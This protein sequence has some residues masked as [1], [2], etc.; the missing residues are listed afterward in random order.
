[1]SSICVQHTVQLRGF[2]ILFYQQAGDLGVGG[3]VGWVIRAHDHPNK[4]GSATW[5]I[6]LDRW[7]HRV[8]PHIQIQQTP[9]EV[10]YWISPGTGPACLCRALMGLGGRRDGSGT[11]PPHWGPGTTAHHTP[12]SETLG[13]SHTVD[14]C[15]HCYTALLHRSAW[16]KKFTSVLK[17]SL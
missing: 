14:L 16:K 6:A 2:L 4:G 13:P 1:M 9:W 12:M 5:E 17:Y 15:S 10:S 8:R 11:S 3:E 7:K